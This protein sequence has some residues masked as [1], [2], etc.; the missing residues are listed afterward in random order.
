VAAPSDEPSPE[1]PSGSKWRVPQKHTG[2]KKGCKRRTLPKVE[3]L[4]E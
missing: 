2:C 1:E 4:L 3:G